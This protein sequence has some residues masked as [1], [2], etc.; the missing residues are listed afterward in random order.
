MKWA[1]LDEVALGMF[2][3]A[4]FAD[5]INLEGVSRGRVVVFVS[6]FLLQSVH[7]G[8]E[9]LHRTAALRTNHMMMAAAIVLMLVAGDA[10]MKSNF[11]GQTA[12]REQLSACDRR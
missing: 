7:F 10:I 3:A 6:D 1:W 11:A 4:I 5:S 8:G 2:L 9:E 12:L